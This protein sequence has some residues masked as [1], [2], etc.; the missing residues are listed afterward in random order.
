MVLAFAKGY[1]KI[2]LYG[3][4]SSYREDTHHAYMQNLNDG[5][6]V[7]DVLAGDKRFRATPWMVQQAE[8]FCTLA[9]MARRSRRGHHG[10]RRRVAAP[11]G[12][13]A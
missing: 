13:V 11:S 3:F 12:A 1:R 5:D 2:H 7:V 9:V 4:D 8:E 6:L 10:R